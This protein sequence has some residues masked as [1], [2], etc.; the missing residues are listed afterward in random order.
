MAVD[1]GAIDWA[2]YHAGEGDRPAGYNGE[3]GGGGSS[4]SSSFSYPN[5]SLN[6][7]GGSAVQFGAN[8]QQGV[9]SAFSKYLETANNQTTPLDYYTQFS[10]ALGIPQLQQTSNSLSGQVNEIEDAIRRVRRGVEQRSRNSLVT[11]GLFD[12][13]VNSEKQPLLDKLDPIATAAG[14]TAQAL[15]E[16]R[17]QAATLTGLGVQGNE[18]KL[19]VA[20]KGVDVATDSAA[21][22]M[23]GFTADREA[24][25]AILF[26]KINKGF[27]WSMEEKRQAAELSKMKL[28]YDMEIEAA[29]KTPNNE[30]ITANG[31]KYLID[32]NTGTRIADLGSSSEGGSGS[33]DVEKV[34]QKLGLL[35]GGTT[36][37]PRDSL[38]SAWEDDGEASGTYQS[39][40]DW[41]AQMYGNA[42][43]KAVGQRS[44]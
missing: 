12:N 20:E 24:N 34:L 21:R 3:G 30:I 31:R 42:T 41:Y 6:D 25:L 2:K 7:V 18:Q 9:D 10:S 8:L 43:G 19:R 29:S 28:Q 32:K 1:Q 23:T 33:G 11:Q 27:E 44:T 13:M 4:S 37:Q 35:G 14:R 38:D 5:I 17:G 16:A 40:E 36:T 22:A 39:A 26:D 15:S